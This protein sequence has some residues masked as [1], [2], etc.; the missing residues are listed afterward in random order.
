MNKKRG[1]YSKRTRKFYDFLKEIDFWAFNQFEKSLQMIREIEN[2]GSVINFQ[3]N[4]S[5]IF[6]K[7]KEYQLKF[8]EMMLVCFNQVVRMVNLLNLQEI[9]SYIERYE[10]GEI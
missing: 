2:L 6:V 8:E 7:E 9:L 1:F 3:S 5:K 10:L 4:N